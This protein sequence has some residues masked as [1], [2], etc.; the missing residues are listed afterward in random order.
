MQYMIN[1]EVKTL[2]GV[3]LPDGGASPGKKGKGG[4]SKKESVTVIDSEQIIDHMKR[5]NHN[6]DT[7][8]RLLV[9][10]DNRSKHV[11]SY[12]V[13]SQKASQNHRNAQQRQHQSSQKGQKGIGVA[14]A[15]GLAADL[16]LGVASATTGPREYF[17]QRDGSQ[18][19]LMR[20]SQ[21]PQVAPTQ[22][23]SAQ[24]GGSRG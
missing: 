19:S 4:R 13:A 16:S 1:G 17:F 3:Q 20:Q 18:D 2:K 6:S 10:D 22:G 21:M 7:L 12:Q 14:A 23:S 5:F 9:S 15:T 8:Y 24:D 11:S